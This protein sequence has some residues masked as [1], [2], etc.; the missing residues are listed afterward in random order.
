MKNR[1][2]FMQGRLSPLVEGRIQSFPWDNWRQEFKDSANMGFTLM[3]WTLD[4]DLLTKN[5][6]MTQLGQQ[7]ILSLCKQ[8]NI[9]IP[10]L[11]GDCFMQQP[12]W[13]ETDQKKRDEL[14]KDFLSIMYACSKIGIKFIVIPIVDN[15][16]LENKYQEDKLV[17]F[18]NYQKNTLKSF[19]IKIVFESDYEPLKL[20]RFMDRFDPNIF[21]INYDIGNSASLGFDPSEEFLFFGKR[22]F[23][24]HVKD[25][26]LNG[27]TVALGEGNAD[28]D[29]VFSLL[30]DYKYKG[31]Y[32]LQ[33]ARSP[34]NE[35]A[36]VLKKYKKFVEQKL[37]KWN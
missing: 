3:E 28:F 5:P 14:Q 22:I 32:I 21:G 20:S 15:G 24:V 18:L 35:H 31:N 6:I 37:I 34:E 16:R 26:E 7:E 19:N 13:K 1:I 12:F 25:R 36:L 30:E 4:Q 33:T 10:S 2:G 17:K 11:T 8:F 23:N 9:S 29:L 27:S